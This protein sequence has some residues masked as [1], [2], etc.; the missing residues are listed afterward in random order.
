MY[1]GTVQNLGD[2]DSN[3]NYDLVYY[4]ADIINSNSTNVAI[5]PN[6]TF[7]ESRN[8]PIIKNSRDYEFSI[9]RFQVNGSG[10][11]LPIFIPNIALGVDNFYNINQVVRS[12]INNNYYICIKTVT[13]GTID[14]SLDTTNWKFY[15]DS[16]ST[17]VL[18]NVVLINGTVIQYVG[19]WVSG[20]A[21]VSMNRNSAINVTTYD[22]AMSYGTNI[23]VHQVVTYEPENKT[24]GVQNN[25]LPN[26]PI[27]SQDVST[28]YYYVYTYDHWVNLINKT[29]LAIFN[30]IKA[31]RGGVLDGYPPFM[32][33]EASSGLFSIYF[34]TELFGEGK[35]MRFFSNNNFYGLFSSFDTIF[36]PLPQSFGTYTNNYTPNEFIIKNKLN[37][38]IWKP[39]AFVGFPT[40]AESYYKITQNYITTSSLWNP[41][42]S[43][44]CTSGLLPVLTET[45]SAPVK[46]GASNNDSTTVSNN[47]IPTIA[48]FAI[49]IKSADAYSNFIFYEPNGEFRMASMLGGSNGEITNIDIQVFWKN[50]LDNKL[51]PLRMFNYSNVSMKML[52]RKKKK[53]IK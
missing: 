42:S 51:Y 38:N 44:V 4:T 16:T 39:N 11:N 40:L 14:P 34:D 46:Y 17:F 37:T 48:D 22:I 18:L 3:G 9:I 8:I 19:N 50:R 20:S 30:N 41:I 52:F 6:V 24:Y 1:R 29:I 5:D 47:F 23:Y 21:Y 2:S 7:Q 35:P 36:N 15:A 13:G 31:A 25:P 26:A 32:T 10:K 49:D 27:T 12:P 28:E 33:Y 43:I 53:L 45:I